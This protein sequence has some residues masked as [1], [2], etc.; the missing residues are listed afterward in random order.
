MLHSLRSK[1]WTL[2]LFAHIVLSILIL[3]L[4]S[5]SLCPSTKIETQL[6]KS[7]SPGS[8]IT[9]STINAP[10][11]SLYGAPTPAL[12]INVATEADVAATV[13]SLPASQP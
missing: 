13:C 10:R 11:W 3:P 8:T 6:G 2:T 5:A 12:V 1:L 7:L 9:N 4:A